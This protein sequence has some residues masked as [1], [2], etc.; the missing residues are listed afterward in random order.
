MKQTVKK[1]IPNWVLR[2][3]TKYKIAQ[4]HKG[5]DVFCPICRSYFNRFGTY[6]LNHRE[7]AR[8]HYCGSLE[9]HRLIWKYVFESSDI[10]K[11]ET[12]L[13]VLHFAPELFF[14]K[15]FSK[16][17]FKTYVP[18]DLFPQKYSYIGPIRIEKVDITEIP[19]EN[20]YFDFII[21]NHVLEHIPDDHKAMSELFRVM[22]KGGQGIFQVPMDTNSDTTYEDWTIT[23]PHERVEAFGQ[24]DHVRLYGNDYKDRLEAVGFQV[25][26]DDYALQF[27]EMERFKY[28]VDGNEIIYKCV[29]P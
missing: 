2:K 26:L 14:Y 13:R 19:Y 15:R 10:L 22:K 16:M 17:K 24:E 18:C 23:E 20:D 3:Y 27:S 28:G 21:C 25:H 7:N 12:A 11:N 1:V 9:R 29:K 8:C 5:Q 4:R 6:G